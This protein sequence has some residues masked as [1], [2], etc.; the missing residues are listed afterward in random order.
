MFSADS[1]GVVMIW[2]SYIQAQ[3]DTKR[4]RK[5]TGGKDMLTVLL[6]K[7]NSNY[8]H[9]KTSKSSSVKRNL[10]EYHIFQFLARIDIYFHPRHASYLHFCFFGSVEFLPC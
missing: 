4:K 7:T 3:V 5:G 1:T 6:H 10:Y 8:I 2:N 9:L